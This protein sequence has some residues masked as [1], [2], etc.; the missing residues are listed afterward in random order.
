MRETDIVARRRHVSTYMARSMAQSH[1]TPA[2][3]IS[4]KSEHGKYDPCLMYEHGYPF[5]NLKF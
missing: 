3:G 2:A 5:M 4:G 1:S